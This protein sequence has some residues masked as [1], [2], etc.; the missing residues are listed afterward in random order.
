MVFQG[1][2]VPLTEDII[3]K[4]IEFV[5]DW[6]QWASDNFEIF[7]ERELALNGADSILLTVPDKHTFYITSAFLNV[8]STTTT[9][10][11]K[12]GQI[13]A[14]TGSGSNAIPPILFSSIFLGGAVISNSLTFPMP[15]KVEEKGVITVR[16]S[17]LSMRVEGGITGFLVPKKI[18]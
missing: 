5:K 13:T 12:W 2:D 14:T 10:A 15:L 7:V 17:A 8:L 18:S 4:K 1:E 3:K 16:S 9:N 6:V 11:I